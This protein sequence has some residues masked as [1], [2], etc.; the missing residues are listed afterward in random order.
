[1]YWLHRDL[2]EIIATTEDGRVTLCIP[3]REPATAY[4]LGI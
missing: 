1:M 3:F 4:W 2:D